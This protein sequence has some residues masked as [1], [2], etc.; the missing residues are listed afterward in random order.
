MEFVCSK[1]CMTLLSE[2]PVKGHCLED[3]GVEMKVIFVEIGCM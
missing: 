1:K 3:V 2:S